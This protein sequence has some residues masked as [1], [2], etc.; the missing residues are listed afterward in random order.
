MKAFYSHNVWLIT[1]DVRLQARAMR[2]GIGSL[3]FSALKHTM[4]L[5]NGPESRSGCSFVDSMPEPWRHLV[6]PKR[7]AML[8]RHHSETLEDPTLSS[9][10][11]AENSTSNYA[12]RRS[13][14]IFFGFARNRDFFAW[15]WNAACN[16]CRNFFD[17]RELCRR[18]FWSYFWTPFVGLGHLLW[19]WDTFLW[20]WD[21]LKV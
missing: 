21:T 1:N 16:F 17:V 9:H 3:S 7:S 20:G 8:F 18:L 15:V 5:K 13:G 19:G 4:T 10:Q 2:S 14:A 11:N 12:Q 6:S